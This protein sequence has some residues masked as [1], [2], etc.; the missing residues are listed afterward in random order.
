MKWTLALFLI[1]PAASLGLGLEDAYYTHEVSENYTRPRWIDVDVR[2][3]LANRIAHSIRWWLFYLLSFHLSRLSFEQV[4]NTFPFLPCSALCCWKPQDYDYMRRR[5]LGS[6][7]SSSHKGSSSSSSSSRKGSSHSSSSSSSSS[8][9]GS[10]S[11][12]SR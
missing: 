7:S 6:S 4:A 10:S 9:K 12:S 11:H 8:H 2:H 3:L 1:L 5:R